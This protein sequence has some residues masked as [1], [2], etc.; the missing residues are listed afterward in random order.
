M[1]SQEIHVD[2]QLVLLGSWPTWIQ[3]CVVLVALTIVV[4]TFLDTRS[5][6]PLWRRLTIVGLRMA[7]V[8][9]LLAMFYEPAI[10]EE[11]VARG[12]NHVAVL[13]DTSE[14]MSLAHG[15]GT[16]LQWVQ[17]FLRDHG[18]LWA[19]LR[20]ENSLR[21][22]S[23]GE[24]LGDLPDLAADPTAID[25]LDTHGRQTLIAGAL[26]TLG[27][28]HRHRD[29]GAVVILTD[30]IDTS[31][32][33][34]APG[35]DPATAATLRDLDAPITLFTHPRHR[36]MRDVAIEDV[37]QPGFAFL[38]NA[39]SLDALVR[40]HGVEKGQL[41][42]RLLENG[43]VLSK[44]TLPMVDGVTDYPVSFDFVPRRLGKQVYGITV[45]PLGGEVYEENNTR[46]MVVQ[47]IRDKIRVLQI[48]GQ[49]SWDERFTRDHLKQ[50]PNIDLISF[51]ILVNPLSHRPVNPSE[52]ALIPFPARELFEE[53]L[54]GFDLVLFQNF[55]YGPFRTRQYL[56]KVAQYVEEGGAFLMVGG[57]L[58]FSSGGYYGTPITRVLPVDVPPGFGSEP[59]VDERPFRP[60]LTPAGRHHPATRL[61][62]DPVVN[63]A[64]WRTL[65]P[66]EGVNLITGA[67][68]DAL[69]LLEHPVV[70]DQRGQALPVVTVREVGA[71]RSMAITT[72]SLWH[73][74]F[75]AGN[76][77]EDPHHYNR[78]WSQAIRWLIRDPAMDLV[79]VQVR[80]E[81]VPVH[82]GARAHVRVFR[83]D[84]R[85]AAHQAVSIRV[86]SR[87]EGAGAGE[88]QVIMDVDDL[89]T[90]GDGR[91]EVEIPLA[92]AGIYEVEASAVVVP[93]RTA[94]GADLFVATERRAEFETIVGD[95]RLPRLL[96]EASGGAVMPLDVDD[97][98]VRVRPSRVTRVMNRSHRDLWTSPWVLLWAACLLGLEWWLR[99]RMGLL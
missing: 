27:A 34:R 14:S 87:D 38:L 43:R 79:R 80:E 86:R 51:F 75:V 15:D 70:R 45:D 44:Q 30:G 36:R 89:R 78:F 42:V 13:V 95:G 92:R 3:V 8:T 12:E 65:Q 69:T 26:T 53:E 22:F 94:L 1:A 56:P 98:V 4:L 37:A 97:P 5:L 96:A 19:E 57:P 93:G 59:L 32:A 6:R 39:T 71:G 83:P 7:A 21:F 28:R 9:L 54:G 55:N 62:L 68:G 82:E 60:R 91:L 74:G 72:D 18:A 84:Y 41:T 52:T 33:G 63:E 64:L 48:V 66:L 2:R 61:D 47:V 11:R 58:S 99:R 17:S 35:L 67:K 88:G 81:R 20:E 73:W 29:L 77:G 23:L 10:E 85:P 90:D 76:R 50:D 49:P 24:E 46:Q 25:D 40:V 31:P 16:R